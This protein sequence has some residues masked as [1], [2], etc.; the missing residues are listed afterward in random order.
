MPTYH[1]AK[2]TSDYDYHAFIEALHR[3]S[4]WQQKYFSLSVHIEYASGRVNTH[5]VMNM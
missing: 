5:K 4:Q 2:E 3:N 1:V